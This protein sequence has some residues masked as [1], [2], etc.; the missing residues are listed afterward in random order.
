MGQ[1]L[2]PGPFKQVESVR[3]FTCNLCI[4]MSL[5]TA[6]ATRSVLCNLCPN[7][8]GKSQDKRVKIK[9][10][11]GSVSWSF[12]DSSNG[13]QG[14]LGFA[15][16]KQSAAVITLSPFL[17]GR[18]RDSLKWNNSQE[19]YSVRCNIKPKKR[20]GEGE[21]CTILCWTWWKRGI[22]FHLVLWWSF[23]TSSEDIA[24]H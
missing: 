18:T 4:L 6:H 19:Y 15:S 2:P 14:H 11:G 7:R 9:C 12:A 13:V 21:K 5:N 16:W 20:R 10:S 22:C 17:K 3:G 1:I 23:T 24:R 8:E